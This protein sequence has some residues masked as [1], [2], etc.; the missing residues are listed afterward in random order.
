VSITG[1][2]YWEGCA[3]T[4]GAEDGQDDLFLVCDQAAAVR[5][6]CRQVYTFE[7]VEPLFAPPR[8]GG[9]DTISACTPPK[10]RRDD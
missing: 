10:G 6:L 2:V 3:L 4:V 7:N 1:P 9:C 5:V 8:N